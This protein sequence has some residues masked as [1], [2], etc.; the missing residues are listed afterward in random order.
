MSTTVVAE[1]RPATGHS[2][3]VEQALRAAVA[4]VRAEDAG[5]ERYELNLDAASGSYVM[6][7]QWADEEAL[8]AHA[9]GPAFAALTA[10][11]DGLLAAPIAVRP[12]VLLV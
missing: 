4:R 11:L 12:L 3:E 7:E 5:C 6:V 8:A 2:Q 10:A 9:A 1:I